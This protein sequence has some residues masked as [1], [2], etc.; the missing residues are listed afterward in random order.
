MDSP[1]APRPLAP[2]LRPHRVERSG[3]DRKRKGR[4]FEEELR[5]DRHERQ[6]PKPPSRP[7]SPD[8][9]P[10]GPPEEGGHLL[11]LEV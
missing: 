10:H 9:P 2:A 5:E 3:R 7:A 4:S 6:A 1:L 11:D 8:T